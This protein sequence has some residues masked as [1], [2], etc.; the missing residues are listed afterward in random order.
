MV[1]QR[2]LGDECSFNKSKLLFLNHCLKRDDHKSD[3][4]C[5]FVY[6]KKDNNNLQKIRRWP[7][8]SNR[9]NMKRSGQRYRY[10]HKD[11]GSSSCTF[12][13][14]ELE[15]KVWNFLLDNPGFMEKKRNDQIHGHSH[16]VIEVQISRKSKVILCP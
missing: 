10:K 13:H 2:C 3:F 15:E 4:V 12:P 5:N 16:S 7:H 9:K 14:S 6:F 1:E 8:K 11:C